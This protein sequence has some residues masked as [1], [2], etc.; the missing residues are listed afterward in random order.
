M[1]LRRVRSAKWC[2][3][4]VADDDGICQLMD[5]LA[6]G[7]DRSDPDC[8]E[9]LALIGR[10]AEEGPPHNK[11]KCRLLKSLSPH[12]GEFKSGLLRVFWFYHG[13]KI[14][15]CTHGEAKAKQRELKRQVRRAERIR[16][17]LLA[18]LGPGEPG[19]ID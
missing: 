14:V 18:S 12:I 17:D 6:E 11:E 8:R 1:Q 13:S 15:V 16:D 4:A 9:M 10:I 7:V 19:I 5:L 3:A 2:V